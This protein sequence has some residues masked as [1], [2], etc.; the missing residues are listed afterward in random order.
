MIPLT[1]TDRKVVERGVHV[2]GCLCTCSTLACKWINTI[3]IIDDTRKAIKNEV[4]TFQ[5]FYELHVYQVHVLQ[6]EN[7]R[8]GL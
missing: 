6:I 5:K 2:L 4:L 1:V 3:I 8:C 7:S